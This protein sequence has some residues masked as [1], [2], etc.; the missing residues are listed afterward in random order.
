MLSD[1]GYR[2]ILGVRFFAGD[3]KQAVALGLRGGLV[4]VP[5]APVL[6]SLVDDPANRAALLDCDFAITDSGLMVLLWNRLKH[7]RIPRVSGLAYLKLF[8]EQPEVRA[9]H[10]TF[11][12][13]PSTK[14][15]E[16]NLAWL[17]QQGHPTTAQ[18][19][20]VAPRY[21]AGPIADEALLQRINS[22]RPA[23]IVMAIGGCTQERLAHYLNTNAEYRPGIHCTGAAIGFLSGDQINI[24]VWADRYY[25]GWLCRCLSAPRTF[26][27]RYWHAQRLI[28][29]LIKHRE[30]CP[31]L[32]GTNVD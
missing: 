23:H 11:W 9:P 17:H 6:L 3:V 30:H 2:Q 31:P 10:A 28:P 18:D 7:D 16:R 26:L 32:S 27:P 29:L 12:I 21:R 1:P 20:Y 4:V 19:C 15:M 13:M 8:L 22:Q 24:P 14:A 5:S 25:L